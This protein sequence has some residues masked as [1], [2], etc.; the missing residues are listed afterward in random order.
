MI[1]PSIELSVNRYISKVNINPTLNYFTRYQF[2]STVY[3]FFKYEKKYGNLLSFSLY[4][5]VRYSF[6]IG[7]KY[8]SIDIYALPWGFSVELPCI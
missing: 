1:T 4:F 2:L 5:Q 3:V 6:I 7:N 8:K